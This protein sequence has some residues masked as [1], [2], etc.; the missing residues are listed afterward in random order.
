MTRPSD[1]ALRRFLAFMGLRWGKAVTVTVDG[2]DFGRRIVH[3]RR[4]D[5]EDGGAH[6]G[7]T[8]ELR[9]PLSAVPGWHGLD[10]GRS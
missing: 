4:T 3:K 10:Y 2:F 7:H 1:A 5:S 8:E 9:S 6:H